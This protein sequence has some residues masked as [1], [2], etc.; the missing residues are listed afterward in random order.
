LVR[1]FSPYKAHFAGYLRGEELAAAYASS[2]AFVYA[3]ETETMGNVILEAMACGLPV[4]AA[5]AGGVTSLVQHGSDGFLFTPR[6]ATE[7]SRYV[8]EIIESVKRQEQ[9]SEAALASVQT[10]TWRN[11]GDEVRAQYQQVISEFQLRLPSQIEN[12]QPGT[13]ATL[14]TKALVR[15]F[16]LLAPGITKPAVNMETSRVHQHV[17]SGV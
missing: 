17:R 7:A 16:Q 3:S 5:N 2:D 10:R 8:R 1:R 14:L 9:M 15:L 6:N 12:R 4:I 11:S 13:M